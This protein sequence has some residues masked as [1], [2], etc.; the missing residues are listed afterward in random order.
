MGA[1]TET[2]VTAVISRRPNKMV[3]KDMLRRQH[4]FFLLKITI[5]TESIQFYIELDWVNWRS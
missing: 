5:R 2:E 4:V 3:Q 1:V